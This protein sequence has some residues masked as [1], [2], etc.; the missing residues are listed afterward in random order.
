M[1]LK[2]RKIKKVLPGAQTP[3]MVEARIAVA[4]AR[5]QSKGTVLALV[6]SSKKGKPPYEIVL[7]A[8]NIAY[9]RC[10]GFK[11]RSECSHM[12]RFKKECKKQIFV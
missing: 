4:L 5:V 10:D 12:A 7:G 8:N 6:P 3:E 2:G 11:Y 9:C 1:I